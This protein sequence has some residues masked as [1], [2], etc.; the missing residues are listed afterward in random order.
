MI[1]Q[2]KIGRQEDALRL[3]DGSPRRPVSAIFMAGIAG[4]SILASALV[5]CS[6]QRT[7]SQSGANEENHRGLLDQKQKVKYRA[8]TGTEGFRTYCALSPPSPDSADGLL[9]EFGLR[10]C[11]FFDDPSK[12]PGRGVERP[13]V[14]TD[15]TP[16]RLLQVVDELAKAIWALPNFDGQLEWIGRLRR[17][18]ATYGQILRN[19][20]DIGLNKSLAAVT[21]EFLEQHKVPIPAAG[22]PRSAENLYV[23]SK[24]CETLIHEIVRESEPYLKL[25]C[26]APGPLTGVLPPENL[27]DSLALLRKVR[28]IFEG[29]TASH[30]PLHHRA[31]AQLLALETALSLHMSGLS[32]D[33]NP[34]LIFFCKN[35]ISKN[36]FDE[37]AR[38]IRMAR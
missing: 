9:Q 16:A 13:L 1:I 15:G 7:R 4:S 8:L 37:A 28:S 6:D 34:A 20:S 2:V 25:V 23:M 3:P 17:L 19:T 35:Y 14:F 11:S 32:K 29:S 31:I 24:S 33:L 18:K 38:E 12:N 26:G 30:S 5:G 27:A 10:V 22:V 21:V 36:E